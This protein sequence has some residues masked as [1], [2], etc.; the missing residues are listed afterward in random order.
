MEIEVRQQD[1]VFATAFVEKVTPDGISVS[2]EGGWKEDETVPFEQCRAVLS[3]SSPL[4]NIKQ[5]DTIDALIKR[6]DISV[7]QKVKVKDIK[8]LLK[9]MENHY[10]VALPFRVRL[11]SLK[12][13]R[14]LRRTKSSL[15]IDVATSA[16]LPL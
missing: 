9:A 3:P 14:V 16:K 5:G 13:L 6:N 8:V 15:L 2:Y 1:G 10:S 4:T 7:W 12:V 11:P